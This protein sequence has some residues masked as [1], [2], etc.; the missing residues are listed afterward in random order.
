MAGKACTLWTSKGNPVHSLCRTCTD[1]L[2]K[3]G[4]ISSI[5]QAVQNFVRLPLHEQ[6]RPA[7]LFRIVTTVPIL[8]LQVCTLQHLGHQTE[9][10]VGRGLLQPG[11]CV[12]G[13]W[14]TAGGHRA[15]SACPET[16]TRF[17]WWIHQL[18]S[19]SGGCG[20]HGGSR[21]GLCVCLTVQPCKCC[22]ILWD[23]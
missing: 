10:N 7:P 9:P 18:G 19:C 15:L 20:G 16:E 2:G 22:A 17:Y 12:Q 8:A 4:F 14:T 3:R 6:M 5:L 11:E 13:A 23:A 21:A 1:Y